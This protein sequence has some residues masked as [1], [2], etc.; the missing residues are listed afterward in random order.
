MT[1][2]DAPP[3]SRRRARR[4]RRGPRAGGR[5]ARAASDALGQVGAVD[6]RS[7]SGSRR[8]PP[9][10][11]VST[12]TTTSSGHD[13]RQVADA[14]PDL[15]AVVGPAPV[16]SSR[17]QVQLGVADAEP[18]GVVHL[19]RPC[20]APGPVADPA[21]HRDVRRHAAAATSDGEQHARARSARGPGRRRHRRPGPGRRRRG[22]REHDLGR[23]VVVGRDV[24][25]RP[26]TPT[27]IRATL[28]VTRP[29]SERSRGGGGGYGA[30]VG[31]GVGRVRTAGGGAARVRRGAGSR[32]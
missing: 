18:V 7:R 15:D 22:S 21:V 16:K 13:D 29:R 2:H 25:A 24:P 8:S 31:T 26:A 32:A 23:H 27:T 12:R 20:A 6:R 1:S 14:L 10:T 4:R 28:S 11:S 5:A 19:A 3:G 17:A 9:L 30:G